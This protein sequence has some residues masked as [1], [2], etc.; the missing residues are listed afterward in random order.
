MENGYDVRFY[1]FLAFV[2]ILIKQLM[3]SSVCLDVNHVLTGLF[4]TNIVE[5]TD[6]KSLD[7]SSPSL[8]ILIFN[9]G[10]L[11]ASLMAI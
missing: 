1:F 7:K 11:L 10:Y 8:T 2:Q 5:C 4:M 3:I 6:P 9:F